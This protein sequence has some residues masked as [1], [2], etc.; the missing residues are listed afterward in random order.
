MY[1]TAPGLVLNI[2]ACVLCYYAASYRQLVV[3]DIGFVIAGLPVM[4]FILAW[5]II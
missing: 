1:S 3:K 2:V 4:S 5:T